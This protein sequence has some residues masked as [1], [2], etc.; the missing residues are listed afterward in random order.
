[1]F[2]HAVP[3]GSRK[4][5]S[6]AGPFYYTLDGYPYP[7]LGVQSMPKINDAY[8]GVTLNGVTVL[9]DLALREA[10]LKYAEA[11][12]PFDF[13]V[14]LH[15]DPHRPNLNQEQGMVALALNNVRHMAT[16]GE[17]SEFRRSVRQWLAGVDSCHGM[18]GIRHGFVPK[19]AIAHHLPAGQLAAEP[20][21]RARVDD[22]MIRLEGRQYNDCY[23]HVRQWCRET[24]PPA[25]LTAL[26]QHMLR[27]C[28]SD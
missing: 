19:L 21:L 25:Q 26:T 1:M 3:H 2:V 12:G 22:A 17:D 15:G 9:S 13:V 24:L 10:W 28:N 4:P 18:H 11:L 16:L 5:A 8:G 14:P 23:E 27:C 20:L 6:F 7:T